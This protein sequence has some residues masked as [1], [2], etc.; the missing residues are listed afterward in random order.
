MAQPSPVRLGLYYPFIQ[1]RSD[2][3]LKL[4]AL[5]WN[6]IG[7]IVPPGYHLQDSDTVQRLMGELDFVTNMKPAFWALDNVSS[8][9]L[10]LLA[11]RGPELTHL[12]GV[13]GEPVVDPGH[14]TQYW[15]PPW[16]NLPSSSSGPQ[17]HEP[18]DPSLVQGADPRLAYIYTKGKM[19]A[20]LEVALIEAGL[21]V[22]LPDDLIG[23]HPQL[24]FVYMHAL[25]S[26]MASSFMCPLT[27]DDFDHVAAGCDAERIARALLDFRTDW[28]ASDFDA[29]DLASKGNAEDLALEFAMLAIQSVIPKDINSLPVQKIIEVRKHHFEELIAFQ[30][31]T[32][33]IIDAVPQTLSSNTE[34]GAIYLQELYNV[35]LK[36]ELRRLKSS[37]QS[38]GI[39]SVLGAMSVKVQ[40]PELVTSG[41]AIFGIGALH[42]NP[43]MMGTGAVVMC[44]IPRIRRQ[45]AEAQRLRTE[46]PAAY[47]LRL[48]EDLSPASLAS[49]VAT[50]A[51]R[52][53]RA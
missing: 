16:S 52:L 42:L 32:Q 40:A 6:K 43:L 15:P 29:E 34:A 1:F 36:P 7:R 5:Y 4:A 51:R 27:D 38:S 28:E 13:Q 10:A 45:R 17:W 48:Q 2:S 50:R 23:M 41:A 12:Y 53:I 19:A 21:G 26:E 44:L 47:L 14:T 25:A 9:F 18:V 3:W 39:D 49:D 30:Q 11:K 22:P 8:E 33:T 24:A 20:E 31:A 37:L 35:T 46:S